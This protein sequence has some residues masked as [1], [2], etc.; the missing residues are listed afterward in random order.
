MN[1]CTKQGSRYSV[2]FGEQVRVHVEGH[3]GPTVAEATGHGTDVDT[4]G[5]ELR[6]S[7]V[8]SR[9]VKGQAL[10]PDAGAQA[11][12]TSGHAVRV[13]RLGAVRHRR[14]DE[15][16]KLV[17]VAGACCDRRSLAV[18]SQHC[19]RRGIERDPSGSS[20]LGGR[21]QEWLVVGPVHDDLM[22]RGHAG[23][24]GWELKGVP[25]KSA[26]LATPQAGRCGE[27][28]HRRELALGGVD[29]AVEL[30]L[31][32]ASG[33][34]STNRGSAGFERRVAGNQ[35]PADGL[36]EGAACCRMDLRDGCG[37]ASFV[38]ARRTGGRGR[39]W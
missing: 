17:G 24:V 13:V 18:A 32:R 31:G 39:G 28:E 34:S 8:P 12:E 36:G 9:L 29:E 1:D 5:D 6:G 21:P 3:A 15:W 16:P 35:P 20:A 25:G 14:E 27:D 4:A 19:H 23:A 26:E 33:L 22:D 30:L 7:E 38:P 37:R 10:D 11:A 2:A